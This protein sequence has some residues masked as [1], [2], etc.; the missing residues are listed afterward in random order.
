MS[1]KMSK[2]EVLFSIASRYSLWFYRNNNCISIYPINNRTSGI[3]SPKDFDFE[4]NMKYGREF[5]EKETFFS[6]FQSLFQSVSLPA[7]HHFSDT[8]GCD[9]SNHVSTAKNCYLSFHATGGCESILYSLSTKINTNN[10]YNSMM[11]WIDCQNIYQSLGSIKSMNIFY[12]KYIINSSN[13][14]CSYNMVN[15]EECLF[16]HD[17]EHK[18]YHISNQEYSQEDYMKQK[19]ILLH[20]KDKLASLYDQMIGIQAINYAS[21]WCTWDFI[22]DSHNVVDGY[23]SHF[24][25]EGARVFFSWHKNGLTNAY[26]AVITSWWSDYY[27]VCAIG[28]DTERAYCSMAL[29]KCFDCYY[30]YYLEWCSFC[31]GCIW[32]Q[33]KQFCILNKQYSKEERYEKVELIFWQME[34]EGVLWK[35]FPWSM[36]PFYFNDSLGYILD[37]SITKEQALANGHLWRDEPIPANVPSNTKIISTNEL[38]NYEGWKDNERHID[39]EILKIIIQ[40]EQWNSYRIMPME[41]TFLQT[42][43]LPLPREHWA[44]RMK[45]HFNR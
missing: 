25:N 30:S 39:P 31:L 22:T 13:I 38:H 43:T 6:Q 9:Y 42:H 12:S 28:W 23:R 21:K 29:R 17:L 8:E 7:F 10:I 20:D 24:V 40:D 33:N 19:V 3:I 26:N 45:K 35:F 2:K 14:W 32:L 44:V 27:N 11:S 1:K 36:C 18:R 34:M 4:E 37:S 41:L 16:C 5:N 15:C